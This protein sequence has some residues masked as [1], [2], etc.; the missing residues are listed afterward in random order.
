VS[1]A[2][3][4]VASLAFAAALAAPA[5]ALTPWNP[6]GI[7]A[8]ERPA[9]VAPWPPSDGPDREAWVEIAMLEDTRSPD[10]SR[11][12]GHLQSGS[13]PVRWRVCRAFAR[14]QDSTVVD[15][16]SDVMAGDPGANVRAEAAFAL[17]QIGSR[18]ASQRLRHAAGEE[19]DSEVKARVI[20]ALGK[21]GD[22]AGVGPVAGFLTS[23][24]PA[25]SREAA[26]ALWRL[27]DSTAVLPLLEGTKMKDAWTRA[28]SAYALERVSRPERVVPAMKRLLEDPAVQVRAYAARA[29]GRQRA[30]NALGPLVAALADR[31][32]RVRIVAVRSFGTLADSAALPQVIAAL[33]DPEAHV[34]ET[35]AQSAAALRSRDA[36][37][38]LRK[39]LRD[40][41]GGVRLAAARAL[42]ALL[43]PPAVRDL[44][45]LLDDRERFVRA[46]VYDALGAAGG[47]EARRLLVAAAESKAATREERSAV[48]GA[49]AAL[50]ARDAQ[51]VIRK[52]LRS[53]DWLEAASAAGAA[54]ASRDSTL[55]P[56][57]VRLY[58]ENP[59][60]REPD[61]PL[62]VL[63]AFATLGPTALRAD[64]AAPGTAETVREVLGHAAE[65]R[66]PRQR[67]EALRAARAV[68]AD[69]VA[70]A[71]FEWQHPEP[72]WQ[73]AALAVYRARLA[74]EDSTGAIGRLTGALLKTTKG[75]IE[76]R[77]DTREAPRTVLNFATL[78]RRGY[79]DGGT[80]H[81]VVPYFVAQDGDPSATGSGGPGYSFRCEYNRL[82]YDT[83]AVGMALSG[84]DTGGSQYF[85]THG[86]QPHL[87]GR[88]TIFAHVV[89]GQD[90]VDRLRRGDRIEKVTLLER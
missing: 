36:A 74:E 15:F 29:L 61:V 72:E 32:P 67:A 81:R 40:G 44:K 88:Y 33:R 8:P 22:P 39:A 38:A 26:I 50:G 49:L 2:A 34:R 35:A 73:P 78:A 89:R 9:E 3:R 63:D 54:A 82:R 55:V 21:I 64:E 71:D 75:T 19:T 77:F 85:I 59:D 68:L 57:L 45:P 46:G 12:L 4:V 11:L 28:F 86:P 51:G 62:A 10:V 56:E 43:G 27:N 37:P 31:D 48:Y 83:G 1:A 6:P 58:R 79:Y 70:F 16:L 23:P 24:D 69:S 47:D 17:G 7:A 25:L 65:T 18:K 14:L 87:D 76:W 20:E 13:R 66:D 60:P 41:D 90:V 42:A 84:K 53:T 5:H 80:W 52:G 30:A